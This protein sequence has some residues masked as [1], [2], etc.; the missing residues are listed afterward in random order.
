MFFT[1]SS[2]CCVYKFHQNDH[3][4][5]KHDIINISNVGKFSFKNDPL[6]LFFIL[7]LFDDTFSSSD[8]IGSYDKTI[9]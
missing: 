4:P 2:A 6:L 9:S 5:L 3:S 7:G 1:A 8:C